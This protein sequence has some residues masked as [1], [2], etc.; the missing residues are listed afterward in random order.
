MINYDYFELHRLSDD[1]VYKFDRKTMSSGE[2]GYQRRDQDLWITY[3][4]E[5]GWVAWDEVAQSIT[6]KPWSILPQK[7]DPDH[8]PEGD[9]VSRNGNKSYAYELKYL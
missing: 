9:W 6:G 5:L 8:P 2:V 3:K 7:Q 1:L 4:L